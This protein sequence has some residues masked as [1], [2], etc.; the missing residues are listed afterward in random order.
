MKK[1]AAH[2]KQQVRKVKGAGQKKSP[3]CIAEEPSVQSFPGG[4]GTRYKCYRCGTK[5]YDLGKPE[6]LCPSCG[7]NQSSEKRVNRRRKKRHNSPSV[8]ADPSAVPM[9]NN[10]I[11]VVSEPDAEYVYDMDDLVL[12]ENENSE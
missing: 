7:F 2:A 5:F 9:G 3:S 4:L 6:S 1:P 8:K 10:D 12:E 11:E